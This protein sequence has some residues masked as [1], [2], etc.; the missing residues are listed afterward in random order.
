MDAA[1][2]AVVERNLSV[3]R[4]PISEPLFSPRADNRDIVYVDAPHPGFDAR[5]WV[6]F[7]VPFRGLG[8][9]W[10]MAITFSVWCAGIALISPRLGLLSIPF[11]ALAAGLQAV[12]FGQAASAGAHDEGG[13]V[14]THWG[15]PDRDDLS[16]LG[17]AFAFAGGA[18]LAPALAAAHAGHGVIA[19][20][21]F[22][23]F[24][25]YWPIALV[26]VG[27]SGSMLT[28]FR[29]I[30]LIRVALRSF[31]HYQRVVSVAALLLLPFVAGVLLGDVTVR[32][33]G[34]TILGP[35]AAYTSGVIGYMMGCLSASNP[36]A[37]RMLRDR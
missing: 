9:L 36:E 28:L 31:R 2:R 17:I 34:M 6:A 26:G 8:I 14:Q 33:L 16:T 29:P 20:G 3:D 25:T 24:L 19:L 23:L 30:L 1:R 15:F 37:F 5:F 21:V 22:V 4:R 10:L 18:V 13:P 12:H 32:F 11:W 35:A 7:T 27:L